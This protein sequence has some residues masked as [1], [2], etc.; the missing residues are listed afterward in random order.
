VTLLTVDEAAARLNISRDHFERHVRR[1]VPR[2]KIGRIYRY[3][4]EDLDRWVEEQKVG[5]SDHA[6]RSSTSASGTRACATRSPR[7][8]QILDEQRRKRQRSTRGSSPADRAA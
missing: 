6:A 1:C 7:A 8:Q 3:D 4:V 5:G 2:V